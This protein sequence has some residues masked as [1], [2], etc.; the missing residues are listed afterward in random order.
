M[1]FGP[2]R[3]VTQG[4]IRPIVVEPIGKR[5]TTQG[6]IATNSA[7]SQTSDTGGP[8]A[9][10]ESEPQQAGGK[11]PLPPTKWCASCGGCLKRRVARRRIRPAFVGRINTPS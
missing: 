7:A 4:R 9:P 5:Q 2:T 6:R 11:L 3:M 1:E 8:L 10:K